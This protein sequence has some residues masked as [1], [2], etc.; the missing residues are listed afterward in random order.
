MESANLTKAQEHVRNAANATCGNSV[1]TAGAEHELAASAFHHATQDTHNDEALRILGLL[2]DHHLKL[3]HLIKETPRRP[4]KDTDSVPQTSDSSTTSP[5]PRR[6]STRSASPSSTTSPTRAPSRRRLPQSSIASNL[7]EKRGIPGARRGTPS[8]APVSLSG[9]FASR[10][11]RPSTPVR[12]LLQR[13]SRKTDDPL[14]DESPRPTK[15]DNAPATPDMS[16]PPEDNFRRFYSAFGGVINAISAPLAFTSLPLNPTAT[17]TPAPSSPTRT[18]KSSKPS[19][20]NPRSTSP[21]TSTS[22]SRNI[23]SSEPDLAALISKP[24]LR[25]LREDQSPLFPFPSQESFYVVPTSGGERS[26]ASI[27][28]NPS[29]HAHH[30]A[31]NPHLDPIT[32]AENERSTAGLRGSSHEE[33][34][35]ASESI[36][37]PSPTTSRRPRS[38]KGSTASN[39]SAPGVTAARSIPAGRGTGLKTLEEL[40]LENETLKHVIDNQS[41]RLIMWET[42]SQSSYNALAQSFRARGGPSLSDPSAL[43]QALAMGSNALPGSGLPSPTTLGSPHTPSQDKDRERERE[44]EA[45]LERQRAADRQRIAAL[46]AQ[47]AS[48]SME[49][50]SLIKQTEKQTLLIGR[51]REHWEKLKAGARKR[52]QAR[53]TGS[54][55]PT[56]V[57]AKKE[58]E[59]EAEEGEVA[60]ED[61]VVEEEAGFGKA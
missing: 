57:E 6:P 38:A 53:R 35:D 22:T 18:T 17:S 28:Q 7:A 36:L 46:E 52:E 24:A 23:K 45:E 9:A 29:A 20:L 15:T 51:Y 26:Y 34:V 58:E 44:R 13:Q 60:V 41:K 14:R 61:S 40:A 5:A 50:D 8:T 55:T 4:P 19:K 27:L 48:L 33:F 59:A 43:A 54:E 42:T 12:D 25:A 39:V 49:K 16:P 11:D 32:E 30:A 31:Q 1:A 56:K 2:Q 21:S 10:N 37:P 47:L 3:A